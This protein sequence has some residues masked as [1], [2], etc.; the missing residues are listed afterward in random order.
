MPILLECPRS[1]LYSISLN[2]LCPSIWVA[3]ELYRHSMELIRLEDHYFPG[4][5]TW[6]PTFHPSFLASVQH[7]L[8]FG[9]LHQLHQGATLPIWASGRVNQILG[10]DWWMGLSCA[11]SN[12]WKEGGIAPSRR[13]AACKDGQ[14]WADLM[15]WLE[16]GVQMWETPMQILDEDN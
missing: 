4:T 5:W 15:Q 9:P 13:A 10:L 3:L 14:T 12:G 7:W 1:P 6:I 2:S 11:I 8:I 16:Y